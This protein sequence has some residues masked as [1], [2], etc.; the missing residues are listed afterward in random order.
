MPSTEGVPEELGIQGGVIPLTDGSGIMDKVFVM[1]SFGRIFE[2]SNNNHNDPSAI[3][4]PMYYAYSL[5][6]NLVVMPTTSAANCS[7]SSDKCY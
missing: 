3:V 7:V 5:L 1:D 6:P 2:E 4:D